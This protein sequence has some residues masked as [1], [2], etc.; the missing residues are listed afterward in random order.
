MMMSKSSC[1]FGLFFQSIGLCANTTV[2][3]KVDTKLYFKPSGNPSLL[4]TKDCTYGPSF[5]CASK[6]NAARCHVSTLETV[7]L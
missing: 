4:G 5:W 2:D 6:E 1:I 3:K 7:I